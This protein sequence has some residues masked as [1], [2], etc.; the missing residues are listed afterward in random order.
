[1]SE[2]VKKGLLVVVILLA[3]VFVGVGANKLFRGDQPQVIKRI[4]GDPNKSMKRLEMEA[5]KAHSPGA[6]SGTGNAVDRDLAGNLPGV[7]GDKTNR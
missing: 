2:T 1:M 3:L 4:E 6:A 7:A 5:Q